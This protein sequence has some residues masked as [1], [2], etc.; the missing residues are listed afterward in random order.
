M[1]FHLPQGSAKHNGEVLENI[2]GFLNKS[3]FNF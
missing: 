3:E 1:V 2:S